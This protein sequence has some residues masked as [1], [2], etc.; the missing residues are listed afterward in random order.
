MRRAQRLSAARSAVVFGLFEEKIMSEE[1]EPLRGYR[2][3][4]EEESALMIEGRDLA[5]RCEEYVAK[6]SDLDDADK[7][8]VAL[9]KTNL[10]QGFMWTINA[11]A[12]PASL[13]ESCEQCRRAWLT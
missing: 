3:F 10:Q 11:I 2:S 6:L 7:R 9:G 8:S 12:Q 1:H 5:A 13:M 4:S